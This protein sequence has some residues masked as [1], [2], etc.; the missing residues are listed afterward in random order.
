LLAKLCNNTSLLSDVPS[1]N[2]RCLW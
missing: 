1:W 2:N